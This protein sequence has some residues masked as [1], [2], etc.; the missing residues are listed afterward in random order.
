M[1]SVMLSVV[2]LNVVMLNVV[3]LTKPP[4]ESN[5]NKYSHHPVRNRMNLAH[6]LDGPNKLECYIA[7]DWKG[8]PGTSALAYWARTKKM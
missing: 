4:E 6:K 8:L 1:L 3:A 7:I 5:L 2:T